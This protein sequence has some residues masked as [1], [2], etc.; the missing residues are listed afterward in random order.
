LK[1]LLEISSIS[2]SFKSFIVELLTLGGAMLLCFFHITCVS[3]LRFIHL[4]PNCG[5]EVLFTCILSTEI[6]LLF[7]Q[8]SVV[9]G[10]MCYFHHW[11]GSYGSA[12]KPSLSSQGNVA[13]FPALLR[14]K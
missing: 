9:A 4:R 7:S 8:D 6:V 5:L 2:L 3:V 12:M 10:L 14:L 11:T 1:S 13:R